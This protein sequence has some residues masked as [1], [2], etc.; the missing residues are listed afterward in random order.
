MCDLVQYANTMNIVRRGML[1]DSVREKEGLSNT[2][3]V[4][5]G[6][7]KTPSKVRLVC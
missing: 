1:S 5:H 2:L 3:R 4:C 7:H 6:W